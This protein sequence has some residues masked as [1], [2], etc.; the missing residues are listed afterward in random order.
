MHDA[1]SLC[2]CAGHVCECA[3]HAHARPWSRNDWLAAGKAAGLS[4]MGAVA[5]SMCMC[6]TSVTG[7]GADTPSNERGKGLRPSPQSS[8]DD[9]L[10]HWRMPNF[11]HTLFHGRRAKP[12][13][14]ARL[15]QGEVGHQLLD[16]APRQQHS[17]RALSQ[18]SLPGLSARMDQRSIDRALH[19]DSFLSCGCVISSSNIA[20]E[21]LFREKKTHESL[22]CNTSMETRVVKGEISRVVKV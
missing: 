17:A 7:E 13:L 14:L 9:L 4:F 8:R 22:D 15:A 2:E 21:G 3:G 6:M 12:E 5:R 20:I 19:V 18:R 11:R 16:V 10:V 1:C